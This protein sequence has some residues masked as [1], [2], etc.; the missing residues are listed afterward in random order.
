MKD[1]T[2]CKWCKNP[3][4]FLKVTSQYTP[5]EF[6]WWECSSKAG[7]G[8]QGPVRGSQSEAADTLKD[9]RLGVEP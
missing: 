5:A 9:V 1:V 4:T 7:C 8:A 6:H 2:P 3:L